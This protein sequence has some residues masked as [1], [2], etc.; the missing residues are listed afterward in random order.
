ML[1]IKRS[2]SECLVLALNPVAGV[3]TRSLYEHKAPKRKNPCGNRSNTLKDK[4]SRHTKAEEE[5]RV[6][7]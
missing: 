1:K 2:H 4:L 6:N 5:E 7:S 3:L